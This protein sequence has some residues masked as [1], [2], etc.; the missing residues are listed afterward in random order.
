MS[1]SSGRKQMGD[2]L[3]EAGI[4]KKVNLAEALKKQ[5]STRKR[6]G[7]I[8]QE[9]GVVCEKDIA[10]VLA[11]QFNISPAPGLLENP[12]SPELLDLVDLQMAMTR[13]VCP[14]SRE[15]KRLNLAM[16]NPLDLATIDDIAFKTDLDV[17]P[18]VSTPSEILAA[19]REHYLDGEVPDNHEMCRILVIEPKEMIRAATVSAL[20]K[21]GY[22]LLEATTCTDGLQSVIRHSPHLVISETVMPGMNGPELFHALQ[23]NPET[24]HI[25]LIGF[26]SKASKEEEVSLLNLGFA[27]FLA[28]PVN[29]ELLKARVARVLDMVYPGQGYSAKKRSMAQDTSSLYEAIHTLLDLLQATLDQEQ[30]PSTESK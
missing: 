4:L 19:I 8:L 22:Q 5:K 17:V 24:R 23:Q 13:L 25:P 27:D 28:K 21:E 6:L 30:P 1:T 29:L 14:I 10:L 9:M 3:I 18:W 16:A 26:S 15:G 11:T 20:H 7:E 12:P 2:L